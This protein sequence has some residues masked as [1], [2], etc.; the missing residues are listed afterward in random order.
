MKIQSQGEIRGMTKQ[1]FLDELRKVLAREL[2]SRAVADNV[3]YYKDYI[4]TA[5]KNG[6]SEERVIYSL[7][8]PRMI[9]RTILQV[10]QRR[11]QSASSRQD[12][13]IY[14]QT[15]SGA[16]DAEDDY[17]GY[18]GYEDWGRDRPRGFGFSLS[19]IKAWLVIALILFMLGLILRTTFVILWR[20]LPAILVV[21]AVVG[22]YRWF[23]R[24]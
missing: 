12:N 10:D 19:G 11:A 16:Y 8:D 23:T 15:G 21:W 1:E 3:Q 20:L 6:N 13:T 24:R 7:G 2:D 14:T 17:A 5:V 4:E 9:A 18:G 22:I